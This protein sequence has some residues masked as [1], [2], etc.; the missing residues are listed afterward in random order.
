MTFG[1][2]ISILLPLALDP[3]LQTAEAYNESDKNQALPTDR[4]NLKHTPQV[5][6]KLMKL[7]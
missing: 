7:R 2:N 1:T 5:F 3:G 6:A 4:M